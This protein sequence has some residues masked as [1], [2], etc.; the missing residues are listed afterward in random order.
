LKARIK[1]VDRAA[2]NAGATKIVAAGAGAAEKFNGS[3]AVVAR[4]VV[5]EPGSVGKG[6]RPKAGI[7]LVGPMNLK[8][9]EHRTSTGGDGPDGSFSMSILVMGANTREA[10]GLFMGAESVRPSLASKDAIVAMEG[11]DVNATLG[12]LGLE[13]A[14]ASERIIATKGDLVIHLD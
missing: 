3:H 13:A 11:A 12:R 1:H 5:I 7:V 2:E 14:F 10:L 4:N 9:Q 6:K 8:V